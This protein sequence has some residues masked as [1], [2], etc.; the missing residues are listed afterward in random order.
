MKRKID[1]VL[2]NWLTN[3]KEAILL[4]GARQVGKTYSI[5]E[6]FK[7]NN[8]PYVEINFA[9]DKASLNLFSKLV[10]AEDFYIKL[11]LT[12]GASLTPHQTCIFLDE[13]QEIY[14]FRED[15][16]K[17]DPELYHR[18]ID[19]ITLMKK[20]VDDG[21][22]RYAISGSLLGISLLEIQSN[23]VG[24]LDTYTLHPLNF[25]EFLW[26]KGVGEDVINYL[27]N[28]LLSTS[29]VDDAIHENLLNTLQQYLLVGGMPDAVSKY[30]KSLNLNE[31]MITQGQIL[32]GYEKDVQ[33][34]A[35]WDQR[36]LIGEAFRSIPSEL[37]RKDKHFRKS[38]LDY[39]NA[40][41]A[42]VS[43][44]FL[45]LANAGVAIPVFNVS[46]PTYPLRLS[47]DRKTVKLFAND[48]GLLSCQLFDKDGAAKVL[49]G[50][51]SM[52]YGAPFENLAAVE[53]AAKGYRLNYFN[54][55]KIGEIDFLIQEKGRVI[56][57]EIKSG[58]PNKGGKYAHPSL[59]NLLNVYQDIE[60]AYVVSKS[61]LYKE[62][63]KITNIPIYMLT[64]FP[65]AF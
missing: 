50:D 39:P 1:Q 40:K 6:C 53:L 64:L 62:N 26:A 16:S 58:A 45:W 13:I 56:P 8:R 21:K 37:N 65:D 5:R 19:P 59:N 61:N 28:Q 25:E 31:V 41:N 51:L 43:D 20:L 27:R 9:T 17:S 15:L 38:R 52:N 36:I 18:T 3:R 42:D 4:F 55:K 32:N 24:Y 47:E 35:P 29:K 2:D 49:N 54:S 46:E 10:S 23:P 44:A 33:K 30:V 11:S 63:G 48:I 22:Y 57:L 34:Y 60:S 7:R 12:A 14:R